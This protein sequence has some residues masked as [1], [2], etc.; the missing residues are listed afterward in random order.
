MDSK[1]FYFVDS[2]RMSVV[3]LMAFELLSKKFLN[4][5]LS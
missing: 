4:L 2:E 5:I 1:L 3:L